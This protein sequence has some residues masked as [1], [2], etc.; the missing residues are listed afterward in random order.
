MRSFVNGLAT[1]FLFLP[2][3]LATS[4]VP[5]NQRSFKAEVLFRLTHPCP[6][7]GQTQGACNGY[8]IDRVIP[9]V[10]GGVEDPSNMQWQTLAEAKVKDRW[11]RIGCRPGRKLVMPGPAAFTEAYPL[12]QPEAPTEIEAL[13]LK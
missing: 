7:T 13:P 5:D 12:E 9:I 2:V 10:C 1:A 11:E 6:G 8:V 4:A 3:S